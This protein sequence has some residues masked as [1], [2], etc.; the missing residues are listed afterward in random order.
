[1]GIK[2]GEILEAVCRGAVQLSVAIDSPSYR[3]H[4]WGRALCYLHYAK[5][6]PSMQ[7]SPII[8]FVARPIVSFVSNCWLGLGKAIAGGC[9]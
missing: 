4:Y 5:E 2:F 9:A 3:L 7:L 1:M 6:A 8:T